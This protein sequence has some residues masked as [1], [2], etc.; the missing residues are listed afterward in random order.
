MSCRD[1]QAIR[2]GPPRAPGFPLEQS[3]RILLS[4]DLHSIES[5]RQVTS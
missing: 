1:Q 2:F 3:M 4:Y 5:N